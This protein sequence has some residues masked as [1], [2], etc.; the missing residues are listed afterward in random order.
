VESDPVAQ[1]RTYKDQLAKRR[2]SRAGPLSGAAGGQR[3]GPVQ[4]ICGVLAQMN[5]RMGRFES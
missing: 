3:I 1:H 4:T 5:D 2:D